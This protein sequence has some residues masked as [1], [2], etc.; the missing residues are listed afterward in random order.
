MD[1]LDLP[2]AGVE[3]VREIG[4]AQGFAVDATE[5]P[6]AFTPDGLARYATLV[7]LSTSGE[8]LDPSGKAALEAYVRGGGGFV[9]VHGAA[10]TEYGWPFYGRLV[11]A[12]FDKHPPVQRATVRVEDRDHPATRHLD[13]AWV[14]TDEWY[15]FRTNPRPDVRVLATVDESSCS[16]G[17]MGADLFATGRLGA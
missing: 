6:A 1:T 14:R 5:Q 7:F 12:W 17:T 9:G 13:T 3:A 11:G 2:H 16:G 8:I 10:A 4:A 15:N